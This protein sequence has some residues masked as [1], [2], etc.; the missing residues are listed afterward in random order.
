MNTHDWALL[1][2]RMPKTHNETPKGKLLSL[3]PFAVP[4]TGLQQFKNPHYRMEI[5]DWLD[6][7][8]TTSDFVFLG[9]IFYFKDEVTA[10]QFK[11]TWR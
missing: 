3:F 8:S 9:N 4:I 7:H 10:M 1:Y 2:S 5:D 6:E 11:L